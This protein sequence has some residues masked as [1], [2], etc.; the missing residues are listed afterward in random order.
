[1]AFTINDVLFLDACQVMMS[2]ISKLSSYLIKDQFRLTRKYLELFYFE[3]RNHPQT[4]NVTEGREEGESM[5]ILEDYRNHPYHPSTLTLVCID[6]FVAV[7]L[8]LCLRNLQFNFA[9]RA[10]VVLTLNRPICVGFAILDLSK[11][12]M[13]D[14]RYNYI[15]RNYPDS[16]L[17]FTDTDSLTY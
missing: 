14:S 5:H 13:H 15:K 2:S 7:F 9:E 3:Q 4:N 1:M 10:K 8:S 17:L 6:S 16:T 11:M 12:L